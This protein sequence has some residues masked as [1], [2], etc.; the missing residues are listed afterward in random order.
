MAT[1]GR[2]PKSPGRGKKGGNKDKDKDE[3][4]PPRPYTE[5]NIFFQLERE[6]ILVELEVRRRTEE[7]MPAS[8]PVE[9]ATPNDDAA[10]HN[11]DTSPDSPRG[12]LGPDEVN[13]PSDPGDVLPRP[14]RFEALRLSPKWYDSTH[15]LAETRR[16]RAR[17]R[18][19]K[20]HGL[21]GFLD[22]TKMIS[23]A[24]RECDAETR[25][26]CR[27][28]ADRQL[29]Y[30]KEELQ[31]LKRKREEE[32]ARNPPPPP[33]PVEEPREE[34][35]ERDDGAGDGPPDE[36]TRHDA[37]VNTDAGGTDRRASA[38]DEPQSSP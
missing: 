7:G 32:A 37:V 17:R 8:P 38:A 36:Q 25:A 31:V 35:E 13:L 14:A 2:S 28:V 15:R 5:Y 10:G 18:H 26:Y 12:F 22:L 21:V 24:W 4:K 23:R 34:E 19:R 16:N 30:Y 9:P 20:T 27:R 29:G 3:K 11:G 6:R 33:P 1:P